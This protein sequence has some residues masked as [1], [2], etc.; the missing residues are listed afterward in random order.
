MSSDAQ[1][2]EPGRPEALPAQAVVEF[3]ATVNAGLVVVGDRLAPAAN[4]YVECDADTGRCPW[5]PEQ[6][7]ILA[8]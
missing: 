5:S 1:A 6:V 4:G 8:P 2:P 7:A 3:G